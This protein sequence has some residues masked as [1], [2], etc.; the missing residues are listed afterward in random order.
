VTNGQQHLP[1]DVTQRSYFVGENRNLWGNGLEMGA[2][3]KT[4]TSN[5][6]RLV[7]YC[8]LACFMVLASRVAMGSSPHRPVSLQRPTNL[9]CDGMTNPLGISNARPQFSWRLP[10]TGVPTKQTAYR[11]L[12]ASDPSLLK[13]GRADIWD[14]GKIDSPE[15][16]NVPYAGPALE[17]R[18]RYYWTIRAFENGD[19]ELADSKPAWFEMGLLSA[20]DWQAQWIARDSKEFSD[21]RAS[22]PLWIG[23][24]APVPPR[25][26]GVVEAKEQ[27]RFV[28]QLSDVPT[29][30]VLFITGRET[31]GAWLNGTQVLAPTPKPPYGNLYRWGTFRTLDVSPQLRAGENALAAEV[32]YNPY[33]GQSPALIA[34]L[35]V[36]MQDGKVV[37]LVT[38]QKWKTTSGASGNWQAESFD[39]ASWPEATN[40]D[41]QGLNGFIPWPPQPAGLLRKSFALTKP[42]I[43][44]RLYVTALGSYQFHIN[45]KRVD[46]QILAPGWTDYRKRIAY[47]TYDVSSMLHI[48]ANAMGALLGEGWYATTLG[49]S[50]RRYNFGFPPPRLLAQLEVR[51]GD[52]SCAVF[53]SDGSWRTSESAVLRSSLYDGEDFDARREQPGWDRI[54]FNALGWENVQIEPGNGALLEGQD[55]Q[56]IRAKIT[57]AP[58]SVVEKSPGVYV[59]DM[60]QNMVGWARLRVSGPR[61][62]KVTM[63]FGEVL[64]REG[65][66]Y[67]SNMRTAREEDTYILRGEGTEIYEPHFTYHGFRYVEVT[68]YPGNPSAD[69]ITGIAFYTDAPRTIRFTSANSGINRLFENIL[70][71]QR[72][73]FESVPTD[74]PQRDERLGWMGDAEVFWRTAVY[75]AHL[76]AFTHKYTADI[77]D[78]QSPSGAYS[79]VSPR[80]PMVGE[81]SP[82]WA[83]A[84]IILPW[85]AYT[86]YR[87]K[88]I[89]SENWDAMQHYMQFLESS[90]PDHLWKNQAYGDWLSI[91]GYTPPAL[92]GTAFWAYDASLMAQMADALGKTSDAKRFRAL[93]ATLRD[94]FNG[95][96][97]QPDGTVGTG[98]QTGYVL[99]LHMNLLPDQ[100]RLAAARKLV[101]NI[102]EHKNHLT[103]GFLGTPFLLLELSRWGYGDIAY[104]LLMQNTMPSWLYMVQHGA[105]T[106]WERWN[107]N[108]VLDDPSMNSFNHYAYGAVGEWLYRY[109]AG[110]DVDPDDPGFHH[111]LLHPQFS[112]RLRKVQAT[113]ESP[114]GPIS[115]SWMASSRRVLWKVTIPANTTA[116]LIFPGNAEVFLNGRP[117]VM[118]PWFSVEEK[119]LK[120]VVYRVGSGNYSFVVEPWG[121]R[122][123]SHLP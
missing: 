108:H 102:R 22:N 54:E 121:K 115:S 1:S 5:R 12:V 50:G 101:D 77:R 111:I 30:A 69:A 19:H 92:I 42:F 36:T 40:L 96:F 38:S 4:I 13:S 64:D 60:G 104:E 46:N 63:R 53:V 90:Y 72:G 106:M 88:R 57:L 75:N 81:G 8:A 2:K 23:P 6:A 105:T 39:D 61:G 29:N 86:Q 41:E 20:S 11:L 109:A 100:L 37:R 99:A 93:F 91:G 65:R 28:F 94:T 35:R 7:C 26:S 70:W 117:I 33:A 17:A 67:N 44:A 9:L 113:Y 59:F 118:Q 84:G 98:S 25:A 78:A 62:A 49:F 82:G 110:I 52:G 18:H 89:L 73:N 51:Y 76:Q 119:A 21:D 68:G 31:L 71:S 79:D 27:Y 48:G 16:V 66:F 45:G 56:P 103:T 85:T 47:Q 55:F 123:F 3:L 107:S 58:R 112:D 14:S 43:S 10:Q 24:A 15:S 83:D 87:D 34:M 32:L 95:T 74:C 114:Y 120:R 97:V 116:S 122:L 80:I